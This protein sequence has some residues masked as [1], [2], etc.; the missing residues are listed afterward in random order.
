LLTVERESL[1]ESNIALRTVLAKIDEEKKELRRDLHANVEKI[2]LPILKRDVAGVRRRPG[3]ATWTSLRRKPAG[4]HR[5]V[6]APSLDGIPEAH[7]HGAGGVQYDTQRDA[8][9]GYRPPP[10]HFRPRR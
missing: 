2:L 3:A 1:R 6:H 9:E 8:H 4:H 7:P 5:P 10:R